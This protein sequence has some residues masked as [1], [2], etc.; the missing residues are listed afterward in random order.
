MRT[1]RQRGRALAALL[2][3]GLS[4]ATGGAAAPASAQA[5]P[6]PIVF[7]HG[8]NNNGAVWN[9]MIDRFVAAG[10][11][12]S[13]LLAISYNSNQSNAAIANQVRSAVDTLRA[14]TGAAKVDVVTHSM[15]GL[16]SRYYLK[17]LGGTT[18]VDEWVSLAGPNHGT[19]AA[20]ACIWFS[21]SCWDMLAGSAFLN[22]LNAGDETPGATR[23]G[24]WWSPTD[25]II[26]PQTSTPLAGAENHTTANIAHGDF[27]TRPDIFTAVHAFVA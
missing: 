1:I 11:P 23:Y 10:H 19:L 21:G 7:V 14:Q 8:W 20:W 4:L 9:T 27:L 25:E 17:N 24:T 3:L 6:D 26:S 2:V 16:S 15:G 12:R 13:R 18:V 22:A 5:A